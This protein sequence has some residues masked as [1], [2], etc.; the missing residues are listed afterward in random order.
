[1]VNPVDLKQKACEDVVNDPNGK[2]DEYDTQLE[3]ERPKL[4]NLLHSLHSL[5]C[6]LCY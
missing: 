1:M 6:H 4:W 2:R 3:T 5:E